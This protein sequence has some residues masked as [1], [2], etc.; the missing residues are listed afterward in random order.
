MAVPAK[1]HL[2]R[3]RRPGLQE[4]PTPALADQHVE[5]F[6]AVLAGDTARARAAT[7]RHLFD[8][9]EELRERSP[10]LFGP[11]PVRRN[12]VVWE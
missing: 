7:R 1:G 6:D 2:D 4:T 8:D 10:G 12:I 3:A 11:A 9:V 5:I